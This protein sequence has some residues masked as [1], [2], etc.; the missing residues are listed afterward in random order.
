MTNLNKVKLLKTIANIDCESN[1]EDSFLKNFLPLYHH[2]IIL[3]MNKFL[4]LGESGVGKTETCRLI[5]NSDGIRAL[6]EN[7]NFIHFPGKTKW[8]AG[9]G[10]TTRLS[11]PKTA[12][13]YMENKDK[14]DWRSVWIGLILGT[15]FQQEKDL[16]N[17]NWAKEI[18]KDIRNCL[19][20]NLSLLPSWF[21]YVRYD[22]ENINYA[23]D[24]LDEELLKCNHWLFI[25]YDEIDTIVPTHLG[26]TQPIS[27][28]LS[29]W[30]DRSRR[31]ERIIPK[32]F[33]HTDLFQSDFLGFPDASKLR[34]H[35]VTLKWTNRLLYQL[36]VKR[37]A[38]SNEEMNAYLR[39]V[40]DLIPS[41]SK[42]K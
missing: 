9:Y 12:Q 23:L 10:G 14:S 4:I 29:F 30:L 41:P 36:L 1:N 37:L 17:H 8:I 40:P 3:D 18:P 35:Q 11:S 28:L 25:T 5:R 27:E 33:L 31:W 42:K 39:M 22:F 2:P 16:S 38:N 26:L 7:L 15:I 20:N 32:I 34:A 24:K 19:T 13:D 6:T 21:Q